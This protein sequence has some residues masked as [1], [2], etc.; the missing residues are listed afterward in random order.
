MVYRG[1]HV[2]FIDCLNEIQYNCKGDM[3]IIDDE[4][5]HI[6][7]SYRQYHLMKRKIRDGHLWRDPEYKTEDGYG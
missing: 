1:G 4:Y 7:H 5:Y 3:A 6:I 2:T